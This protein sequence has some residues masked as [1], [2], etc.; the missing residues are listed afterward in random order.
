[1]RCRPVPLQDVQT[2]VPGNSSKRGSEEITPKPLQG[3][4][5]FSVQLI[6]KLSFVIFVKNRG[7]P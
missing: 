7:G 5:V 1:M 3:L 6:F 2:C 4:Q